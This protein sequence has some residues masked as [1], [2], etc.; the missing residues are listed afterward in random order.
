MAASRKLESKIIDLQI[1]FWSHRFLYKQWNSNLPP[2]LSQNQ[3]AI[4]AEDFTESVQAADVEAFITQQRGP[5][6]NCPMIICWHMW[7]I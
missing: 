7:H 4:T 5:H 2:T 3:I 1:S 6:Q